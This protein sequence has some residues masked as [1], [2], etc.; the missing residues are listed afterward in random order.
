MTAAV[1]AAG[2]TAEAG[3]RSFNLPRGD[4]ATTLKQFAATAGTPIVYLVERV[5][6][7]TT[8]AV[9]GEFTPREALERMLAGSALEA[10]QDAATGALVVSRKRTAETA[11]RTRE[12]GPVSD[13]Q[14]NPHKMPMK[15]SRTL[16]AVLSGW[17]TATLLSA[18]PSPSAPAAGATD[19]AVQLSP[20]Q[21]NAAKDEGYIA[22]NTLSGSRVNTPLYTT[23]SVTSVFTRD[24]L[25]DIAANDL[26]EAYRYALNTVGQEQPGQSPNFRANIFSDNSVEV[27]GL[28]AATARNYFVW[29]VNGDGYNL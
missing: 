8:N 21:V 24:F 3:K 28:S 7:E 25:N 1:S 22:T 12:V 16:L 18:Q 6:G 29:T 20:F 11:P 15:S 26:V 23:P 9:R 14:T 17:L 4:A 10:A 19:S 5:R 2:A 13:P 27:R